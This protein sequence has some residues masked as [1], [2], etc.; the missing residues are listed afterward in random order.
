MPLF[1]GQV[2]QLYTLDDWAHESLYVWVYNLPTTTKTEVLTPTGDSGITVTP[3]D[4]LPRPAIT[5]LVLSAGTDADTQ[6]KIEFTISDDPT[7]GS[8]EGNV[9]LYDYYTQA[10]VVPDV[11]TGDEITVTP[12]STHKWFIRQFDLATPTANFSDSNAPEFTASASSG[13]V[14]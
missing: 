4:T 2:P 13:G 10:L 6:I 11:T 8:G 3:V 5:D 12:L 14:I 7:P 9:D 1:Q